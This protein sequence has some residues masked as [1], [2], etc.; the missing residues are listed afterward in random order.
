MNRRTTEIARALEKNDIIHNVIHSIGGGH[1]IGR[2]GGRGVERI[3][4]ITVSGSHAA[5]RGFSCFAVVD[6]RDV[7]SSG[8]VVTHCSGV[9]S[10]SY[11]FGDG[12]SVSSRRRGI[13]STEHGYSFASQPFRMMHSSAWN[14][15][16][17]SLEG[18][19]Q[20]QQ[21]QQQTTG[22][23]AS[24]LGSGLDT[25]RSVVKSNVPVE[26]IYADAE[27]CDEAIEDLENVRR[28]V[29]SWKKLPPGHVPLTVRVKNITSAVLHGAKVVL[30]F[31]ISIPGRIYRF[32]SLPREERKATYSRWWGVVKTEAKHYWLGLKLL[33]K[34]TKIASRLLG[35]VLSGK[36]LS[37]RERQ[38]L[39]RTTADI[40]RLVPMMVFLVV[41]FMELL[42]PVALKLFP[43]MLPSTFEDKLKKEEDMKK[44]VAARLEIARFLQDTVAEMAGDMTAHRSGDTRT[45]AAELYGFMQRVRA[46]ENVDTSEL[47]KFAKLFND[48]LTLDNLERVQL[49]SL[50]RFVGISPFGTDAFLKTR[51]RS[52]LIEIK[53]DD[54]EIQE[55]GIEN[56]TEDELRQACRARGMRAPFGEGAV[57]FMRQQLEEWLDW[58]LNRSL[59]SSLLL[60]SRAFTVTSPV[61]QPSSV[62]VSS[63]RETLS[64]MPEEVVEDVELF[65]TSSADK[66]DA[67]ERKLELLEREEEL[68]REEQECEMDLNLPAMS[69]TGS[70]AEKAATAAAA[71]VVKEAAASSLADVLDRESAEEKSFKAAAAKQAKMQK[72]LNALAALASSS[73]VISEREAF[74]DLVENEI[75][76]LQASMGNQGTGMVFT[77]GQLNVDRSRIEEAL[78][79]RRLEDRVTN[80]LKRVEKELDMVES[81]IGNKFRVLDVDNDG[82]VC[83]IC[84]NIHRIHLHLFPS[85]MYAYIY[86]A[87]FRRRN[88]ASYDIFERAVGRG[89]TQSH[90]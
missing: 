54:Q 50:C 79:Q 31:T 74:M 25:S 30:S 44:R 78:G 67:Y 48:E 51:L 26:D 17:S 83:C 88:E 39:T 28:R 56:L 87:D 66:S 86:P 49:V 13:Y 15:Y 76:R 16:S 11:V 63:I 80:I 75:A 53:S 32:Y 61:G 77:K 33:G 71:A 36:T 43:N 1:E 82:V 18:Q 45:S 5:G 21:G 3:A 42:L 9:C 90:A 52:H 35:R 14:V 12:T 65:A 84:S 2:C 22:V 72:I 34:D 57:K 60:L 20:Q 37:R 24:V 62:D 29:Q 7:D 40:F 69:T 38:Q 81:K 58:S 41:P 64:T 19:Q 47:L 73:G 59:P 27:E 8:G 55:E 46:G 6:E 70:A 85:Y 4:S 10:P 23:R 89:R 68:I